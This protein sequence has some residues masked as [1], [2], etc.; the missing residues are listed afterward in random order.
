MAAIRWTQ[1]YEHPGPVYSDSQVA[2]TWLSHGPGRTA[3]TSR[4]LLYRLK[5]AQQ[6]LAEHPIKVPVYKWEKRWGENPADYGRKKRTS[7]R[8]GS[9]Q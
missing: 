7:L 6:W 3:C 1:E 9:Q 8:P 2:L 4:L 5:E